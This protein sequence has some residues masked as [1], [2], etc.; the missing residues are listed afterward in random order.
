MTEVVDVL[1]EDRSITD[2]KLLQFCC[3]TVPSKSI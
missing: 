1:K 2:D 3:R